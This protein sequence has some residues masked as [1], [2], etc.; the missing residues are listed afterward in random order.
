VQWLA[1]RAYVKWNDPEARL[2]KKMYPISGGPSWMDTELYTIRAK[3]EGTPTD[4]EMRGPMLQA[5]LEERFKLRMRRELK[6]E[7]V[8]ELRIAESGL[9]MKAVKEE[10][11]VALTPE[12]K[13]A[14]EKEQAEANKNSSTLVVVMPPLRCGLSGGGNTV[15]GVRSIEGRGVPIDQI[16]FRLPK[17]PIVIDKTGL[18]GRF[19]FKLT[20]TPDA[21]TG[22]DPSDLSPEVPTGYGSLFVEI[23]KQLGL[24]LVPVNGPRDYYFVEHVERPTPN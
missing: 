1:E 3:A 21:T 15:A 4:Q 19:D 7:R 18:K 12:Q 11:C 20:Y 2:P 17:E 22:R 13:E 24:K 10:E 9:K 23:E 16:I 5:L 14:H 6:Q 8:Y